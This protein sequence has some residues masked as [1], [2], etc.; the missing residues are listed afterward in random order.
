MPAV[1]E[2]RPPPSDEAKRWRAA[3]RSWQDLQV[4]PRGVRGEEHRMPVAINEEDVDDQ[5]AADVVGLTAR[6]DLLR[7]SLDAG[8]ARAHRA[9]PNCRD[10]VERVGVA[11][12]RDLGRGVEE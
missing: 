3:L 1:P 8:Q 6:D 4:G 9:S 10:S 11:S 2:H 7:E 5:V 12:D